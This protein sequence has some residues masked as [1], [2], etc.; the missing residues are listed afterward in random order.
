MIVTT[1]KCYKENDKIKFYTERSPLGGSE[2]YSASKSLC[3]D[4][5]KFIFIKIKKV[6]KKIVTV[7][8][9]NVI[10]GGDWKK[11]N[12]IVPDIIRSIINKKKLKIRNPKNTRPW[13]H[14]LDCLNGY[15]IAAEYSFKKKYSFNTWN[16]APPLI[17]K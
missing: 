6:K 16:F 3:R 8:A 1:D 12:R 14:V 5:L 9:G 11:K 4:Y 17:I 13:L 2:P 15:L 10:G 7:R